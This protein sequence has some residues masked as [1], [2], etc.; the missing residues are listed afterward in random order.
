VSDNKTVEVDLDIPCPKCG[1]PGARI[2]CGEVESCFTC[3]AKRPDPRDARIA[4]LEAGL[5]DK[6]SECDYADDVCRTQQ[7]RAEQAESRVKE[8][9]STIVSQQEEL[10]RLRK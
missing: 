8:L 5:A 2:V 4:E 3:W 6:K 7:L 9:E 10:W 1:K